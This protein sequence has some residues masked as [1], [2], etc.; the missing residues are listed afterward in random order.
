[1]SS[2]RVHALWLAAGFVFSGVFAGGCAHQK[3]TRAASA[4][5]TASSTAA[6]AAASTPA[7]SVAAQAATRPDLSPIHFG[8][9]DTIVQKT[10]E[11]TLYSI[12]S[13]LATHLQATLSIA[14]Y[15]DERGTV[16]YNIALGDRRAQ[17]ARDFIARLG[18]SP[19]RVRT[20]SY[21]K[22]NPVDPG[23]DEAAWARNRRDEFA[24]GAAQASR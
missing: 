8:F 1:M 16:E 3:A 12:G 21:G 20:V 2:S 7:P 19:A 10:D 24:L 18:V 13:Y 14:G 23:H 4:L 9:D 17:A 6:P 22:E 15:C 5:P 11:P